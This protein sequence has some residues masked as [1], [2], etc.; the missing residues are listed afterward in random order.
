MATQSLSATESQ[1]HKLKS[2]RE[3]STSSVARLNGNCTEP[4]NASNV[5]PC[6][7]SLTIGCTLHEDEKRMSQARKYFGNL[8][9]G[10]VIATVRV[11][12]ALPIEIYIYH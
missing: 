5:T 7:G 6:S 4:G 12:L 10:V 9:I 3:I 1:T 2:D 11:L 8:V